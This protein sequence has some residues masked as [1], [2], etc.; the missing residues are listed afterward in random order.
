MDI[1]VL[2]QGSNDG[3]SFTRKGLLKKSRLLRRYAPRKKINGFRIARF[4]IATVACGSFAMTTNK[5]IRDK[6]VS[7]D[8]KIRTIGR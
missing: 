8:A 5:I 2:C 3:L 7:T 4:E 1:V 6:T